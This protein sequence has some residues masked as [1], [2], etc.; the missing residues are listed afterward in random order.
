M[1]RWISEKLPTAYMVPPHC[2]SWRTVS[3][4]PVA[5]SFGV[6]VSGVANTGPVAAA[7]LAVVWAAVELAT[8]GS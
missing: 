2:T 5:A 1:N 8:A 7:A 4:V 6:L 3:V